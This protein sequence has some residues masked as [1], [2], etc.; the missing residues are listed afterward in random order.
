MDPVLRAPSYC[1]DQVP[2]PTWKSVAV[3]VSDIPMRGANR[4]SEPLA[5][6]VGPILPRSRFRRL[7]TG[8]TRCISISRMLIERG[9]NQTMK[10]TATA[11]RFEDAFLMTTFLPPQI[12]LGL[13]GRSLSCSR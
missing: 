10:L 5:L 11:T 9:S 3:F 7:I 13:S 6:T 1:E 4:S 12:G 8:S 2:L